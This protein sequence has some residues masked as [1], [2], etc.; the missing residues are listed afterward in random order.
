MKFTSL[1]LLGFQLGLTTLV[2]AQHETS[3]SLE[4]L[5]GYDR[6][7]Y[8]S[9]GA[10]AN[11]VME[12]AGLTQRAAAYFKE[13]LN[14]A[15]STPLYVLKPS[16]WAEHSAH[17]LY[18][19][20]N[21][22]NG[23]LVVASDDNEFW[24]SFLPPIEQLPP[25]LAQDVKKAYGMKDGKT[26]MRPFF[27]LLALLELGHAFHSDGKLNMQRKWMGE[28]FVNIM[29]HTYVAEKE[30]ERLPALEV[31]PQMVVG[32]GTSEYKYTSLADFE[33]LYDT[34]GGK[35]YGWYQSKLHV[36]AKSIYESAGP[37]VLQKLWA[38]LEKHPEKLSDEE[39]VRVL[40]EEVHPAVAHVYVNW[41]K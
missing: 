24:Q 10:D 13:L 15:P 4:R 23:K 14:V 22:Q 26:S 11:R 6:P 37:E 25:N 30:K 12:I 21:Y 2:S 39:F 41:N 40:E 8:Y 16:D 32:A 33:R 20:A 35:N 9:K 31:F 18:G 3:A 38:A 17:P 36:G 27:D 7:V 28:L 1:V 29:L 19:M 5:D 34:V